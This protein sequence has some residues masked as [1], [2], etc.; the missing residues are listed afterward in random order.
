MYTV[1]EVHLAKKLEG[2]LVL[3]RDVLLLLLG[4]DVAAVN[5]LQICGRKFATESHRNNEVVLILCLLSELEQGDFSE[6]V[7]ETCLPRVGLEHLSYILSCTIGSLVCAYNLVEE[8]LAVENVAQNRV[9]T[10]GTGQ[11]IQG[12]SVRDNSAPGALQ[13]TN[14]STHEAGFGIAKGLVGM[15]VE[16][17]DSRV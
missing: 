14:D 7:V 6:D 15:S 16:D 8:E 12:R 9:V 13:P 2:Q 11:T 3:I 10:S 1:L 4:D 17:K 5:D